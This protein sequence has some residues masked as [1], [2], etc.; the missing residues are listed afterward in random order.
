MSSRSAAVSLKPGRDKPVRQR[1]PWIFSGAIKSIPQ[2]FADGDI[3]PVHDSN[4]QFLAYG[5]LNR[6]SQIQVRILTWEEDEVFDD[7]FWRGRLQAAADLR[8]KLNIEQRTNAYRLVNAESDY[9]PGLVVDHYAGHLVLQIGSLGVDLRKRMLAELLQEVT[10]CQTIT[11]R[12]DSA[13]R[14]QEGLAV[15]DGALSD[16]ETPSL[17]EV[18]EN[19]A[20]YLVD[21]VNG[22]KTGF[23]SDQRDNRQ[24][25]A[26]YCR[27]ARVLN[28]FSYTGGFA[29]A[30]LQA[31]AEHVMNIDT[32]YEALELGEEN[33]RLNQFDPDVQSESIVGDVF[34]VLRDAKALDPSEAG[35]DVAILDP[36]KFVHNRGNM[37][38][39]LRGY[40][41]INL[42]A[43][44][45]L[46]P[47]SILAT[48]SCSG[49]VDADLFQKVIFGAALDA[50][51][52]LR[53]LERLSQGADHPIAITF[54]EGSYLTGLICHVL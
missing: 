10:G 51:R 14:N 46:K 41:D 53:I 22:Q 21:I 40:K 29:V 3:V 20:R 25:V 44:R 49:L 52:D 9:L 30:A 42:S 24:R 37:E 17:V 45:L 18:H 26:D 33:L 32:S 2:T 8:R 23:Y 31:D 4:G 5:F 13:A 47:D 11:E 12:S 1:H 6:H 19:G 28:A 35:F 50:G 43:L 54:P 27:N 39:G 38:R 36:P 48:F 15:A 34:E 7:E 16:A